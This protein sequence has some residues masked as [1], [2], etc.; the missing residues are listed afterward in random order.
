MTESATPSQ[1]TQSRVTEHSLPRRPRTLRSQVTD[2]VVGLV[3]LVSVVVEGVRGNPLG[4]FLA[5]SFVLLVG[6]FL[7]AGSTYGR[8]RFTSGE[9]SGR[10]YVSFYEDSLPGPEVFPNLR[11]VDRS[12]RSQFGR[13]RRSAGKL[14]ILPHGLRWNAESSF[15]SPSQLI[16]GVCFLPWSWI[17]VVDLGDAWIKI[18]ALGGAMSI[19]L[20]EDR[21]TLEGE[22]RGSHKQLLK[23]LRETPLG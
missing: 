12:R 2:W 1:R 17:A 4:I 11:R 15:L 8:I 13:P 7:I 9:F 16:E 14:R 23:V 19:Q 20:T 10:L 3:V 5:G 21:G 22:F 18:P 6:G